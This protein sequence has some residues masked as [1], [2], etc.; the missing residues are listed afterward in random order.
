MSD[1]AF[2]LISIDP[3]AALIGAVEVLYKD[4]SVVAIVPTVSLLPL[5]GETAVKG[6]QL[7]SATLA[8]FKPNPSDTPVKS[9]LTPEIVCAVELLYKPPVLPAT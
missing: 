2:A 9:A 1:C 4:A 8:D 6:P 3:L 5:Y 7:L